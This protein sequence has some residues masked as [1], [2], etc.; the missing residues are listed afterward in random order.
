MAL[1]GWVPLDSRSWWGALF[2]FMF[3]I[4]NEIPPLGKGRKQDPIFGKSKGLFQK[5]VDKQNDWNMSQFPMS[6]FVTTCPFKPTKTCFFNAQFCLDRPGDSQ[7]WGVFLL[8]IHTMWRSWK[9]HHTHHLRPTHRAHFPNRK[10][11]FYHHQIYPESKTE[12]QFCSPWI[13]HPSKTLPPH[14]RSIWQHV[15][16]PLGVEKSAEFPPTNMEV[17][18]SWFKGNRATSQCQR[19]PRKKLQGNKALTTPFLE[20]FEMMVDDP[21]IRPAIVF[22]KGGFGGRSLNFH[23]TWKWM[24]QI[25]RF[26][27]HLPNDP[28]S[29]QELPLSLNLW[30]KTNGTF[31]LNE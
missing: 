15:E 23:E 29:T 14:R 18:H 25:W 12:G 4:P 22:W 7:N 1:E 24:T 8:L 13:S 20:M 28:L 9:D 3:K 2:R 30:L 17:D 31:R 6:G 10:V 16:Q 21:F 11:R 27:T 5:Y 19:A 26:S